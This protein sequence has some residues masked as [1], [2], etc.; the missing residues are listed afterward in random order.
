[1]SPSTGVSSVVVE[2][3]VPVPVLVEKLLAVEEKNSVAD[4]E[5]LVVRVVPVVN[6]LKHA[7]I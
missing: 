2:A 7:N 5:G 1:M 3:V 4:S 6:G